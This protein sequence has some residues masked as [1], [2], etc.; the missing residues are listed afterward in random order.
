MTN[1]PKRSRRRFQISATLADGSKRWFYKGRDLATPTG[2]VMGWLIDKAPAWVYHRAEA[3][4]ELVFV[5]ANYAD[6]YTQFDMEEI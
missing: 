4:R 6:E 3:Q 5:R 1:H 2:W